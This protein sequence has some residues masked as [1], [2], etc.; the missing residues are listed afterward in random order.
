MA[1][2][3]LEEPL[4]PSTSKLPDFKKSVKLK[5]VKLGYHTLISHGMYLVLAPFTVLLAQQLSTFKRQDLFVIWDNLQYN[6]VSVILCSGLVVFIL[7]IYFLT[8]PRPVYLVDFCC[9]K[10]PDS[11]ICSNKLF[12]QQS[13]LVESFKKE[14]LEFQRKILE[15]S[16]LGESTYLPEVMFCTPPK[17]SVES[18]RK[19]AEIVMF[20]AVDGLLAK[21]SIKPKDIGILIVNC[22]LF[23]PTPS[24]TAMIV[25]HYKLRG[26]IVSYNLAGMGCSAG[27]IAVDLANKLL[28]THRSSYALVVSTENIT[29]NWYL[30]DKY[31]PWT[32]EIDKF[33][34]DIPKVSH[35]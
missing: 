34:V 2:S 1:E 11:S 15:R 9:Y 20:G 14:S 10:P 35:M 29:Q 6:L 28:Q 27:V 18:A 4:N 23:N 8:C 24:L 25:N 32:A 21:T 5:Y 31:N 13:S 19:E 22:S 3:N 26:N 16:G 30:G 7:T 33:P 17:I 12:M